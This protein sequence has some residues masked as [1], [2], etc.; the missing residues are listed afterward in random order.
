MSK[1]NK[2]I[3]YL[4][5]NFDRENKNVKGS[6]IL[7]SSIKEGS[8]IPL[9]SFLRKHTMGSIYKNSK[10]IDLKGVDVLL[11]G[12]SNQFDVDINDEHEATDLYSGA[13]FNAGDR[14][15][16]EMHMLEYIQIAI[17]MGI[18]II[19]YG[20]AGF[21]LAQE[22][23][24]LTPITR[25]HSRL[26][27]NPAFG[28]FERNPIVHDNL[29]YDASL[30][31]FKSH[32]DMVIYP[33]NKNIG[34]YKILSSALTKVSAGRT[35]GGV[36]NFPKLKGIYKGLIKVNDLVK[37]KYAGKEDEYYINPE[38]VYFPKANAISFTEN[39]FLPGKEVGFID[40]HAYKKKYFEIIRLFIMNMI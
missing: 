9:P 18:P 14:E 17:D 29:F 37:D 27:H 23:G 40:Y 16:D 4:S 1:L 30:R 5:V 8:S 6:S 34:T 11:I 36:V 15:F 32:H 22:Q 13:F 24:C 39:P 33:F 38:T 20:S 21:C 7:L 10:E 3:N 26:V 31:Q 2:D 28:E 12:D 25:S 19:A 35:G